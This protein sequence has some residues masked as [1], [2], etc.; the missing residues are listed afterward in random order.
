MKALNHFPLHNLSKYPA[1]ALTGHGLSLSTSWRPLFVALK[2]GFLPVPNVTE[3]TELGHLELLQTV[4][5][6]GNR[7]I[8]VVWWCDVSLV[9]EKFN[10]SG[11]RIHPYSLEIIKEEEL[12]NP[13]SSSKIPSKELIK[14]LINI[15]RH[16]SNHHRTDCSLLPSK[17]RKN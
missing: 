3:Q 9:L 17:F 15:A 12:V 7:I 5:K 11:K 13:L 6:Y 14:S 16:A 1:K 2:G 4:P 8:V 10:C